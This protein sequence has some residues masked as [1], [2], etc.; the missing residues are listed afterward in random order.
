MKYDVMFYEAFQEEA[1]SLQRHL[2]AGCRAGY[3]V[4]TVQASGDL[5]PPAPIIS[6]RLAARNP[7]PAGPHH[8]L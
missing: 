7:G 8:R 2:P 4:Q 1:E 6:I 5:A 3:N